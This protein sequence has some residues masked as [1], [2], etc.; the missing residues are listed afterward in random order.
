[1]FS[2]KL[3]SVLREQKEIPKPQV[4][5]V[6][7]GVLLPIPLFHVVSLLVQDGIGLETDVSWVL[8]AVWFHYSYS[9]LRCH[10][11]SST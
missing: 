5:T 2:G 9:M 11:I 1:M 4:S 6:E 10:S 3:R 7:K 8:L